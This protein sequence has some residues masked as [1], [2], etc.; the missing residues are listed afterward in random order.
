MF[1]NNIRHIG[2]VNTYAK[3]KAF[4]ESTPLPK[5]RTKRIWED[6]E[7]P[8][9][10]KYQHHYRLVKVD[11]ETY[12]LHLY[13]KIMARFHRPDADGNELRQY[14]HDGRI[15]SKQFMYHVLN[16]T[17]DQPCLTTTGDVALVPIR[18]DLRDTELLFDNRNRLI[19][20]RSSH[21][22]LYRAMSTDED[23]MRNKAVR[24]FF[25]PFVT[26][27]MFRMPEYLEGFRYDYSKGIPFGQG[28]TVSY[29]E[30]E[31]MRDFFN[32]PD[33]DAIRDIAVNTIIHDSAQLVYDSMMSRR[34]HDRLG[35][36]AR[37]FYREHHV[38]MLTNN[39]ELVTEKQLEKALLDRL[40]RTIGKRVSGKEL[41]PK[42]CKPGDFPYTN[43]FY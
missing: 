32:C 15:T 12:E 42:F 7:R 17:C 25:R 3:A 24:D 13:H 29:G 43:N 28:S 35:Y 20:D 21:M 19:V 11:E 33:S 22:Q 34:I 23:K 38:E 4:Y 10:G 40:V 39:N 18:G 14:A 9:Q 6:N 27:C 5:W 2:S 30:R 37:A 41:I 26:V 36:S 8:L 1:S 16:V 31:S